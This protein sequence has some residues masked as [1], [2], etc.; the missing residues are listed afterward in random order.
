MRAVIL[1]AG[2][3]NRLRPFTESHPKVLMCFGPETL[4]RRHL[5]CLTSVGV[6]EI[7]IV[8]GH[9][10]EQIEEEVVRIQPRVPV[11]FLWNEQYRAGSAI[12]LLTAADVL[13]QG[14]TIAMDA[15]LLYSAEILERLVRAD[16]CNAL[17]VD[18]ALEDSGEEVK[19]VTRDGAH[20]W[21]L[22]KKIRGEGRVVGESV[23]IFKFDGTAGARL[24]TLLAAHSA[25]NPSIEYEPVVEA[26][27]RETPLAFVPVDGL[28]WI[29]IDFPGDVERARQLV[30]PRLQAVVVQS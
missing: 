5:H 20:V 14:P 26:L 16:A 9:L 17:L 29:E 28:P 23:G 18:R 3:G 25:R 13:R 11:R 27:A 1:A 10:R 7:T 15:D 24:V 2:I 6:D 8:T 22:A 12:S 4:L 30:Y 21:E 19:V